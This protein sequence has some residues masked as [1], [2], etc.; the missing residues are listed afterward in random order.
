MFKN[1]AKEI[2][3]LMRSFNKLNLPLKL[4]ILA[5]VVFVIYKYVH[6]PRILG[7]SFKNTLN[8]TEGFG[9]KSLTYYRMEGCPHCARFDSA[10]Q[11]FKSKNDSNVAARKVDSKDP[12]CQQNGVQGFPTILLTDSTNNKLKE[13]PTR[14][15]DEMIQFCKDNQ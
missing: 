5:V 15:T 3:S 13:C 8:V 9:S 12:E 7:F 2:K 11:D 6:K 4:V 14:D 10:W 1:V